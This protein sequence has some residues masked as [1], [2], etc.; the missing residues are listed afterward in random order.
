MT[1]EDLDRIEQPDVEM[2][3]VV[4]AKTLRFKRVPD[5]EVEFHGEEP[6]EQVSDTERENLPDQVEPGVTYRDVRVRWRAGARIRS[7]GRPG[8]G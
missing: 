6:R 8:R 7:G 2:G 3:A 4:K 1:E 5:V